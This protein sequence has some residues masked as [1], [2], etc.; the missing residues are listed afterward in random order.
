MFPYHAT[1]T[2]VMPKDVF[3]TCGKIW[4]GNLGPVMLKELDPGAVDWPL[5]RRCLCPGPFV[6]EVAFTGSLGK[7]FMELLGTWMR[8]AEFSVKQ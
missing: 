3:K 1:L 4:T 5:D 7:F 2:F 8:I 6:V